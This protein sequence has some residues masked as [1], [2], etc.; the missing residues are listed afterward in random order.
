MRLAVL[1][2]AL[3]ASC[4]WADS[5]P[6]LQL[7]AA[8]DRD[9]PEILEIDQAAGGALTEG[10]LRRE[11]RPLNMNYSVV[12]L[13]HK[14]VGY[15]VY[16]AAERAFELKRVVVD[17]AA[18]QKGVAD[19]MVQSLVSRVSV[20]GR[21][22]VRAEVSAKQQDLLDSLL[23]SQF[24]IVFEAAGR[25]KLEAAPLSRLAIN[26]A[27]LQYLTH[28]ELLGVAENA[29]PDEIRR[30]FERRA[31]AN[32]TNPSVVAQ[33]TQAHD[34]LLSREKRA[35]YDETH[36][37]N[38]DAL[39]NPSHTL[40]NRLGVP[41]DA[42][43]ELIASAYQRAVRKL[44]QGSPVGGRRADRSQR[45]VDEAFAILGRATLRE[46]YDALSTG[47]GGPHAAAVKKFVKRAP[48]DLPALQELLGFDTQAM[49]A[50]DI[51]GLMRT[52]TEDQIQDRYLTLKRRYSDL[53]W[54]FPEVASACRV[55]LSPLLR[56]YYDGHYPS[57]TSRERRELLHE[58]AVYE[59]KYLEL[60]AQNQ[61]NLE[62]GI[63]SPLSCETEGER[64]PA[65]DPKEARTEPL[66][67][68]MLGVTRGASA[69]DIRRGYATM[70][71]VT[72]GN[73]Q[74]LAEGENAY[75]VLSTPQYKR[76]YDRTLSDSETIDVAKDREAAVT[77]MALARVSEVVM[78]PGATGVDEFV[79]A[80]FTGLSRIG[81]SAGLAKKY[82]QEMLAAVDRTPGPLKE[83][84]FRLGISATQAVGQHFTGP[85]WNEIRDL[86]QQVRGRLV[87]RAIGDSTS[88]AARDRFLAAY[89]S[90]R[91][92]D[93]LS[94]RL[95]DARD[96]LAEGGR[97]PGLPC[98][99]SRIKPR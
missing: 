10:K 65:A 58:M 43:L 69:D 66:L 49:D 27:E 71:R 96:A 20:D 88:S 64:Q 46:Q 5:K 41:A 70:K 48:Q 21:T 63:T 28:Y 17:P 54:K 76:Q 52:S 24:D 75:L 19:A 1:C 81:D 37:A 22:L 89:L 38:L 47:P 16:A 3:L 33:L 59:Q 60:A 87:A 98:D 86:E 45:S 18:Q 2:F 35:A 73:P 9:I 92:P 94:A 74:Q 11:I 7:R 84:T 79:G 40:Y 30:A 14:V 42:S 15:M 95:R 4:V 55:L 68:R 31:L 99:W 93:Y 50:Y 23:R 78:H 39:G 51:L 83:S 97:M 90:M 61:R 13:D 67:Y 62:Y 29:Q 12:L 72:R 82:L 44:Y 8:L 6:V 56:A 91:S 25:L 26:P 85:E 36:V 57:L 77:I 32:Q 34:V 53:D 80:T